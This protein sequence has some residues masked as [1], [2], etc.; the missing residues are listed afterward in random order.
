MWL[1]WRCWSI[2]SWP[3]Y[4]CPAVTERPK[5]WVHRDDQHLVWSRLAHTGQKTATASRFFLVRNL[6][7]VFSDGYSIR[8]KKW[9][10]LFKIKKVSSCDVTWWPG[11]ERLVQ[12]WHGL[13]CAHRTCCACFFAHLKMVWKTTWFSFSQ[14]GW[15][16]CFWPLSCPHMHGLHGQFL[17]FQKN[18]SNNSPKS[19]LRNP[20]E[21]QI[22]KSHPINS[23][24][25]T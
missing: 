18:N 12:E 22:S 19:W 16:R 20:Y 21:I 14:T 25:T 24:N 3:G 10:H 1:T 5:V 23:S 4:F 8:F 15:L 11:A 6:V 13:C 17:L 2:D 7:P 9:W